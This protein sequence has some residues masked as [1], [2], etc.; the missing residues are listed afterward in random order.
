[1]DLYESEQE[2]SF[3]GTSQEDWHGSGSFPSSVRARHNSRE[4][5]PLLKKDASK[6]YTV[7]SATYCLCMFALMD[8]LHFL[9]CDRVSHLHFEI[10]ELSSLICCIAP[11]VSCLCLPVLWSQAVCHLLPD[12]ACVLGLCIM[13]LKLCT[14]NFTNIIKQTVHHDHTVFI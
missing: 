7:L 5:E 3:E 6:I 1:M 9:Y 2:K 8:I 11:G 4:Q 13:I 14:T 12:F 10:D